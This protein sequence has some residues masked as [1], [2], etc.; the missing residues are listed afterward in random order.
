MAVSDYSSTVNNNTSIS[1]INIA[2][3]CSPAGLNNAL[4]QMMADIKD[5]ANT[6]DVGSDIQGYSANL[7][8]ISGVT[9]VADHGLYFSDVNTIETFSLSGAGRALVNRSSNAS[10]RDYL[11]LGGAA[12]I[13]TTTNSDFTVNP[14]Q[15]SNRATTAGMVDDKIA[16]YVPP[17]PAFG[18]VGDTAF[19]EQIATTGTIIAGQEYAGSSLRYSGVRVADAEGQG[20]FSSDGGATVVGT[21]AARG[22]VATNSNRHAAT[23]F[24]RVL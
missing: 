17:I 1:G 4:R 16:A 9:P 5:L 14:T 20:V 6:L 19:L 18:T 10:M 24:V 22:T 12:L 7:Q 2:E 8:A 15:L 3:G 21:W 23:L 13:N 11:A